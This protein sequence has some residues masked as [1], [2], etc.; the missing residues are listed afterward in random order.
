MGSAWFGSAWFGSAWFGSAW[1]GGGGTGTPTFAMR[2]DQPLADFQIA[3][4]SSATFPDY[5][6]RMWD[7]DLFALSVLPEFFGKNLPSG[8]WKDLIT[9]TPPGAITQADL[10]RLTVLAVTERPEALG[11]IVEQHQNFQVD[12]LQ[13]L[14]MDG[15]TH[16]NTILLMKLA[17]RVGEVV[18][19]YYKRQFARTSQRPRPSQLLPTLFPP[20][21]VPGHAPYPAGHAVIA[22]LTA[23]CLADLRPPLRPVL[24]EMARRVW[25]NRMIAG[26]H[27]ESDCIA[28]VQIAEQVLPILKE[29]PTYILVKGKASSEF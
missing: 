14:T 23:I 26:L 20:V 21:A 24:I 12:F 13:L 1:S 29:C 16:P 6:N 19:I 10:D 9:V 17:A 22:H 4:N 5:P 15:A 25:F 11:E 18:M 28:G 7:P 8:Y 27:Y 2:A 3:Q